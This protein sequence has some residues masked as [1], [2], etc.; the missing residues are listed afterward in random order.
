VDLQGDAAREL[1][2]RI[3]AVDLAERILGFWERRPEVS[4]P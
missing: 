4:K 3:S 2:S 1:G